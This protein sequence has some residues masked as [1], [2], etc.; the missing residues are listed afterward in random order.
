MRMRSAEWWQ[1]KEDKEARMVIRMSA[2]AVGGRDN[3]ISLRV[4]EAGQR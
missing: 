2:L 3:S 1:D 4:G